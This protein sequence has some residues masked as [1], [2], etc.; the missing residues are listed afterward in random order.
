MIIY[1]LLKCCYIFFEVFLKNTLSE[2]AKGIKHLL[3]YDKEI[4]LDAG[5]EVPL[6]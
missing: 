1:C 2:S 6:V 3:F 5:E 4:C